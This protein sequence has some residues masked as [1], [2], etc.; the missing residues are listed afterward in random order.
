VAIKNLIDFRGGYA[1]S[2]TSELMRDNELL[3]AENCNWRDGLVKRN[4]LTIYDATD[5]S[6]MVGM[7]G[8]IR[9][10]LNSTWYTIIALDDNTNVRIY[11]GTGTTF[12]QID[13]TFTL[14]KAKNVEFAE[15]L[16]HVVGVNGTDKPFV[17][18]YD[19]G[20]QIENLE[21]HDIRT[22]AA[23]NW[24]AGQWDD[25]GATTSFIDDT[26]DAQDAGAAD[27]QLG[28]TTNNDGFYVSCDYS[29][30]RVVFTNASQA[31]GAPVAEYMYYGG[32]TAGWVTLGTLVTTPDWTAAAGDKTLEFN[33]PLGSDGVSL[34]ERYD[35]D[36]DT[37]GIQNKFVIRVRFTT[38]ASGAFTANLLAL[39]HTQYLTEVLQNGRPHLVK[40]HNQ[41]IYMAEKNIVN[42]SPPNQVTG[43]RAGQAEY[44]IDGGA[45]ITGLESMNDTLVVAKEN[46]LYTWTTSNLLDPVRSRPLASVGCCAPRSFVKVGPVIAF[47]AKDGIYV[48]DGARA[49][50]VSKHIRSDIESWT[51]TNACAVDY[52]GEYWISFPTNSV[53]LVFDIDTYR[54]DDM[55]DGRVSFY[56]YTTYKV[57]QFVNCK[58]D[59]DT[60][61]LLALVDQSSPYVA[62]CDSGLQDNLGTA[63]NIN[64]VAKTKYYS[65]DEPQVQKRYGRLKAKLK[66]VS[67]HTGERHKLTIY[68]DEGRVHE[69]VIVTVPKGS[70]YHTEDIRVPYTI[71][72]NLI[73]LETRHNGPTLATLVGYALEV[74][75]RSY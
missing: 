23:I 13:A 33:I 43:W 35:V 24:Y 50:K 54:T 8:G 45:T 73:S 60:G 9:A 32:S 30:N 69:H 29:F 64:M 28:N 22:R 56:K 63:T 10:Y 5:L 7:K 42:F 41:Q 74:V 26:T 47:A 55:G 11:A 2:L 3:T 53:T 51:L 52:K 12:T 27:F 49:S 59:S 21:L 16:G 20:L 25:D 6:A 68:A 15:L 4:G 40:T 62:R 48:W 44:F 37:T 70:G 61:Y 17:V 72:G 31:G 14:T 65:F 38:A 57:H 67:A 34:W 58:G 18:Y 19:S 39:Y 1:T 75:E 66:Q 36:E 46:T 71:D